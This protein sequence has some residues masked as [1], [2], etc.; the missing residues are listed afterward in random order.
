MSSET[1]PKRAAQNRLASIHVSR[2]GETSGRSRNVLPKEHR[3][4]R[5]SDLRNRSANRSHREPGQK[6]ALS[7]DAALHFGRKSSITS[8]NPIAQGGG[9]ARVAKNS[10]AQV[11]D[12]LVRPERFELPASW[13]VARR[14]IQLSYGRKGHLTAI[15]FNNRSRAKAPFKCPSGYRPRVAR[16]EPRY[17]PGL[18]TRPGRV[19]G[20]NITTSIADRHSVAPV[21]KAGPTPAAPILPTLARPSPRGR[22]GPSRIPAV[23][24]VLQRR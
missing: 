1:L 15:H 18:K 4:I 16:L 11:L 22:A 3:S 2:Q 8:R 9:I 7:I 14:S 17:S 21:S 5:V 6:P 19:R 24:N 23:R 13:F 12:K 10:T 20:A